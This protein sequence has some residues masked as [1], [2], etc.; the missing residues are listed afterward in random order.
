MFICSSLS[1]FKKLF[2]YIATKF[3]KSTRKLMNPPIDVKPS[4]KPQRSLSSCLKILRHSE[5]FPSKPFHQNPVKVSN[6]NHTTQYIQLS[7]RENI[8]RQFSIK[9]KFP[10]QPIHLCTSFSATR[11]FFSS[12][13]KRNRKLQLK[14][15]YKRA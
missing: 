15:S 5:T 12:K 8:F 7:K 9:P 11:N 6:S 2:S 3:S 14:M 4:S 13:T 10:S 1:S